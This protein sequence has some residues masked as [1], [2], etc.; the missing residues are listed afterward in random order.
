MLERIRDFNNVLQRGLEEST[1][2]LAQRLPGLWRDLATLEDRMQRKLPLLRERLEALEREL[3]EWSP[4]PR[5]AAPA[6]GLIEV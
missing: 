4:P 3:R 6:T 5:R 2:E 1:G